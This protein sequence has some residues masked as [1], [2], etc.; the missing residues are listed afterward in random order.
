MGFFL[1]KT[2]EC[3]LLPI[4]IC[5]ILT[6]AG[7]ILRRRWMIVTG[8]IVLLA[9]STGLAAWLLTAPLENAYEAKPISQC[10]TADAIVVLSGN[11]V[12]GIAAPGP[13]FG[14]GANRYF[15]GLNLA[16]A[17]KA[18]TIVFTGAPLNGGTETE[19]GILR[20]VAIQQGVAP[21]R[22]VVTGQVL[23]T[24]EEANAVSSVPGIRSILL[25]TSA[26]HMPRAS[27]LFRATG[28]RV[29]PFPTD[30]HY[31]AGAPSFLFSL[32]PTADGLW[33]SDAA[34]REYYGLAVYRTLLLFR[35][36]R[37]AG[38]GE[39]GSMWAGKA[40][41]ASARVARSTATN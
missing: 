22:I 27:M 2:V 9:F 26:M 40:Y 18:K 37:S 33:Q 35:H 19:G 16:L 12:R 7:L 3:L 11:I 28:L 17:G 23:T 39:T 30:E 21:D 14:D 34:L 31:L 20:Q 10:P 41:S 32:L 24:A 13:Q 25:V 15:T 38:Y 6:I 8:L 5:G 36:P 1:R 29:T 4:G